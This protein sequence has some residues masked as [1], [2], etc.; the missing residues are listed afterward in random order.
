MLYLC[1]NSLLEIGADMAGQR[2]LERDKII[3]IDGTTGKPFTLEDETDP[4]LEADQDKLLDDVLAEFDSTADDV[5][6]T[7]RINRVLGAGK[8]GIKEPYLFAV[9]AAEIHGVRDR[10]RDEYGSGTYRIRI[11]KNNKIARQLDYQI[12]APT[13]KTTPA[14]TSDPSLNAIIQILQDSNKQQME[15]MERIARQST[16]VAPPVAAIDPI[17]MMEKLSTIMKNIAP[18][19]VAAPETNLDTFM[20]AAEFVRDMTPDGNSGGG[21]WMEVLKEVLRHPSVGE[22]IATIATNRAPP[23]RR[24]APVIA[25]PANPTIA[26]PAQP[27]TPVNQQS[28]AALGEQLQNNIRYL[29]GRAEGGSNPDLYAEWLLDN[30]NEQLITGMI[31][32][33]NL[34]TQ[35]EP[36][37]PRMVAHHEWFVALIEAGKALIAS[38]F[39]QPETG[40]HEPVGNATHGPGGAGGDDNHP[41]TDG[42]MD[43]PGEA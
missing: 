5:V 19:P 43:A 18:V 8:L 9:D 41:E 28:Q 17:A 39:Y 4:S 33:P 11:Y 21:G 38:G 31:N 25:Q 26:P 10:L 20:K 12:E 22:A 15:L 34:L 40:E 32:D 14:N 7:A 1:S 27:Q 37:F 23:Q 16:A 24:Q 42:Q 30:T 29:I 36:A 2:R 3:E 13:K 35:L 6:Y